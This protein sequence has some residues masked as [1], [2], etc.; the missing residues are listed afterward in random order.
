M[1]SRDI[2]D[3]VPE[4]QE[5]WPLLR[6][7]YKLLFPNRELFLTCTHRSQQEQAALFAKNTEHNI[8]TRCDGI[9]KLSKH[10]YFPAKA[11]DVGIK[12]RGLVVWDNG[13]FMPLGRVLRE[14]DKEGH[15]R[16][17][18]EFSFFDGPHFEAING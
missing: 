9:K 4:L 16:W 13:Y 11:F 14:L 10:N 5:F 7:R 18:G 1:A 3:C 17:G 12:L 8:I 2:T 6:D 15:I